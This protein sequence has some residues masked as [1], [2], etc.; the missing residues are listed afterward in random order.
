MNTLQSTQ[1]FTMRDA[2]NVLFRHKVRGVLFFLTCIALAV[3]VIKW[4]PRSY[5]SESKLLIRVGRE[6]VTI[7]PTASIGQQ[8]NVGDTRENEI[9]S[10]LEI[11]NSRELAEKVVD[12]LGNATFTAVKQ[13]QRPEVT[14]NTAVTRYMARLKT[15]AVRKTNILYLSYEAQN[16]EI[17]Q[18]VLHVLIKFYFDKHISIYRTPGS[19]EFF[20]EQTRNLDW[21]V[22]RS[23]D[24]L[25]SILS[26]AGFVSVESQVKI[27]SERITNLS[28]DL[29]RTEGDL[30][31]A[32][33]RAR[34]LMA[35]QAQQEAKVSENALEAKSAT[36]KSLLNQAQAELQ[37]INAINAKISRLTRLGDIA[38]SNYRRY[39][40]N[41]EQAR[42]DQALKSE[43]I[44]NIG[45]VQEPTLP[46]KPIRPKKAV[47]AILS[48]L[49][50]VFG[51]LGVAFGA[52]LF[53]HTLKNAF[54]AQRSLDKPVMATIP[55]ARVIGNEKELIAHL[56]LSKT[57]PSRRRARQGHR[58]RHP[59][60]LFREHADFL[61]KS[62]ST[63]NGR[64][65]AIA[66][67][68]GGEGSSTVALRAAAALA[69]SSDSRVL[70]IDANALEPTLH[71]LLKVKNEQGFFDIAKGVTPAI[72]QISP[73]LDF[74]AAGTVDAGAASLSD[75]TALT[76][77]FA[78]FR[79]RY[80]WTVID[81][82]PLGRSPLLLSLRKLLDGA[83]IVIEAERTRL[84]TAQQAIGQLGDVGIDAVGLVLNKKRYYLPSWLYKLL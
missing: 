14:R 34:D 83:V 62:P 68:A 73:V 23:E 84:E 71:A 8:L 57:T 38:T 37:S 30:S 27:L 4:Y 29:D 39:A 54:E 19:Y 53:D 21:Q 51:S 59:F 49:I 2:V 43:K 22:R 78:G 74:I 10:E 56:S 40:E 70:V 75:S 11:L 1:A 36:L 44:S 16:P 61:F 15:E 7:D 79:S 64:V 45:I 9:N 17:A 66:G 46:V 48:L 28:V 41:L 55:Y 76:E 6:S 25:K 81:A 35:Q 20:S 60:E 13:S 50:A 47:I 18:K 67:P 77:A 5:L 26:T 65:L 58:V 72:T 33:I 12:S 69:A 63:G 82:P 52:E 3:A 24:T 32:R 31:A 80:A 42:I